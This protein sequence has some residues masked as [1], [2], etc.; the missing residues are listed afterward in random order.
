M[1]KVGGQGFGVLK[2]ISDGCSLCLRMCMMHV[3]VC[4]IMS[5]LL[6]IQIEYDEFLQVVVMIDYSALAKCTKGLS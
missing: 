5:L 4:A 6:L 2:W 3:F 1:M